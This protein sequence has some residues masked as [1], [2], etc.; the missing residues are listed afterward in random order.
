M[1]HMLKALPW[2]WRRVQGEP[3]IAELLQVPFRNATQGHRTR[4]KASS[5]AYCKI[6]YLT[7]ALS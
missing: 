1:T 4:K 7:H 5:Q 2:G 3:G 6:L